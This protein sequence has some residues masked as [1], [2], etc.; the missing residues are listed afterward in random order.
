MSGKPRLEEDVLG[1]AA[2]D[3]GAEFLEEF[4]NE[5]SGIVVAL[6]AGDEID[7]VEMD[8]KLPAVDSF[9]QA[10]VRIG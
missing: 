9:Y 6:G 1:V 2:L 4:T 10:H 8:G 7:G 5:P 3:K